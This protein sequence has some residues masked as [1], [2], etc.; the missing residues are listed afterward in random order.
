MRYTYIK[1][2]FPYSNPLANALVVVAGAV[3]IT[4]SLIV[5]FFA[6]LVLAA[7]VLVSAAVIGIRVWWLK[8][9]LARRS[10]QHGEASRGASAE[11]IEGEYRVVRDD[12]DRS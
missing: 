9:K 2:E 6:F 1:R 10:G 11:V 12:R 3:I 8:R 7:L 4:V 5:G